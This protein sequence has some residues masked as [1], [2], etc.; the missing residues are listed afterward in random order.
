MESRSAVSTM[1]E[2]SLYFKSG[3]VLT[4]GGIGNIH[5]SDAFLSDHSATCS[6]FCANTVSLDNYG[7][8]EHLRVS[9]KVVRCR[10]ILCCKFYALHVIF[11]VTVGRARKMVL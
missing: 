6:A 2:P 10:V 5:W 1:L 4:N 9:P 8:L 3:K 7:H 11:H